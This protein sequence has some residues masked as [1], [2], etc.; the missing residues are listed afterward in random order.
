MQILVSSF[1]NA[2]SSIT[3][4][5]FVKISS[6]TNVFTTSSVPDVEVLTDVSQTIY[7]NGVNDGEAANPNSTVQTKREGRKPSFRNVP[8]HRYL[9][10]PTSSNENE[11]LVSMA[12]GEDYDP[13]VDVTAVVPESVQ[14]NLH[15]KLWKLRSFKVIRQITLNWLYNHGLTDL[16]NDFTKELRTTKKTQCGVAPNFSPCIPIEEANFRFGG[17][18]REKLIPYSCQHLCKYNIT[19]AE[20]QVYAEFCMYYQSF[21]ALRMGM[22]T[23]NAAVRHSVKYSVVLEMESKDSASNT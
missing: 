2:T 10:V 15:G 11:S 20:T 14:R 21:D 6:T 5:S 22:T 9:P 4:G 16:D 23:V 18:C 17:C 12:S 7:K 13:V 1:A 3:T 19:E 8:K